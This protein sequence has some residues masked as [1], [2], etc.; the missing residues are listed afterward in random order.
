MLHGL[1][2]YLLKHNADTGT[3]SGGGA[4]ST[5]ETQDTGESPQQATVAVDTEA[6]KTQAM[7]DLLTSLGVSSIDE[8]KNN[9]ASWNEYQ[10]GQKTELQKAQDNLT[11]ANNS[12]AERDTT[13]ANLQA[14]LAAAQMGVPADNTSDVITL[15]KGLVNE[16]TDIN[17]AITKVLEK[18]P[19]FKGGGGNGVDKPSFMT[20]TQSQNETSEDA[21]RK[22]LGLK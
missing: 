1:K 6:I 7:T 10:D 11:T 14:Q 18:Y 2:L 8:A 17:Q 21:F 3:G 22:A 20:Q 13:I 16:Q 15:A 4:A 9:L 19:H 5:A 12:L